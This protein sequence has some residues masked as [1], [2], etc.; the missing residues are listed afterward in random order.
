MA[1]HDQ[2]PI[3]TIKLSTREKK[4]L[5]EGVNAQSRS[6]GTTRKDQ[7]QLRADFNIGEVIARIMLTN[8]MSILCSVIPRNISTQGLSFFHGRYVHPGC[9]TILNLPTLAGH[10]AE[11]PG[12]VVRCRHVNGVLHELGVEF[13]DPID[14]SEFV[15][16]NS[17]ESLQHHREKREA[18]CE[19]GRALVIDDLEADRKLYGMW[20]G[21]LGLIVNE[22]SN[23]EEALCLLKFTPDIN[24]VLVGMHLGDE[25]GVAL[26]KQIHEAYPGV[27]VIG[28]SADEDED[29]EKAASAAGASMFLHK[30][31]DSTALRDAAVSVLLAKGDGMM[32]AGPISSTLAHDPDMLPLIESFVDQLSDIANQLERALVTNDTKAVDHIAM[33]LKGAGGGYGFDP[34]TH[35]AKGVIATRRSEAGNPNE[36]TRAVNALISVARSARVTAPDGDPLAG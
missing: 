6:L 31:F 8:G 15:T 18:E 12:K 4:R 3:E 28:V 34:I 33:Q 20:L 16:L 29:V 32:P 30:P 26:L 27:A 13:A 14:V 22:A 25:D 7:R 36:I 1:S 2:A 10:T 11:V 5:V 24:L 9:A 35:A 19:F 23:T 17:Q 21:K